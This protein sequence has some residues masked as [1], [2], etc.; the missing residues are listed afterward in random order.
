MTLIFNDKKVIIPTYLPTDM[1]C[2]ESRYLQPKF[3]LLLPNRY[4]K[5]RKIKLKQDELP[6][7]IRYAMSSFI[8]RSTIFTILTKP[9]SK[10]YAGRSMCKKKQ[11]FTMFC[12][13]CS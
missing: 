5:V 6:L 11:L 4:L 12:N 7:C 3:F 2:I 10:V 13:L 8:G 1:E 9:P